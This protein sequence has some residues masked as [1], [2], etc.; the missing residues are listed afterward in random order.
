MQ[1]QMEAIGAYHS[2][3]TMSRRHESAMQFND[4]V[5]N[6]KEIESQRVGSHLQ[7]HA[8]EFQID[9]QLFK[10]EENPMMYLRSPEST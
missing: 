4:S 5:S 10:E 3:P 1:T 2:K 7:T 9:D 6:T 8:S